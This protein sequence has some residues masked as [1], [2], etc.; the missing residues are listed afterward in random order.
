LKTP[1]SLEELIAALRCLPGVGPEIRAA[2][3]LSPATAG[4]A[5]R[6]APRQTRSAR[7]S[8]AYVTARSATAMRRKPIC[9]LCRSPRRDPALLC[10]VERL[11]ICS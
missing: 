1:S 4:Q 9:T 3:G 6:A 10:V 8:S 11:P 2:H 7:R 5:G